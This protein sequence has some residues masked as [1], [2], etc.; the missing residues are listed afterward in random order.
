MLKC[1]PSSSD[2]FT[3]K[4]WDVFRACKW[5]GHSD[6]ACLTEM[7]T[8]VCAAS[9]Y[10]VT[11]VLR[12]SLSNIES[13]LHTRPNM[14]VVHLFRDPRAIINSHLRTAWSQVRKN[15]LDSIDAAARSIC[16]RIEDD[17]KHA[18]VLS[19]N[20]PERFLILQ[21]EDFNKPLQKIRK[22]LDFLGMEFTKEVL[23]FIDS[24]N[25]TSSVENRPGNH[26]FMYREQ[27]GWEAMKVINRHC[28]KV[29]HQL[30]YTIFQSEDT[31]RDLSI[32]A[33][34]SPLPFALL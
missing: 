22:L 31:F 16:T 23:Q 14:K 33:V 4:R 17:V 2:C 20:F 5:K 29:F 24:D 12:I 9:K 19:K 1:H 34:N 25:K 13:F 3:G 10:K 11:K 21:Y 7:A 30:G 26:P 8:K 28:I 32:P 15:S 6:T 27:L 18:M